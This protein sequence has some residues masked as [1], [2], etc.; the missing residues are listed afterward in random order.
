MKGIIHR[1]LKP[2]NVLVTAAGEPKV[3]DFG[4]AKAT[5]P[6][7]ASMNTVSGAAIGTPYYMAPEQAEGR[8]RDID[9]RTDVFSLGVM[10][11]ESIAG[12]VPFRGESLME[13]L[14]RIRNDDPPRFRGPTDLWLIVA[15]ALEKEKARRY[16]TADSLAEDL[17]RFLSGDPVSARAATLGF[18]ARRWIRRNPARAAGAAGA[19]LVAIAATGWWW[20][21]PGR[22]EFRSKTAGVWF[23]VDGRPAS[24]GGI[25]VRAGRHR[26][27]AGADGHVTES[28]DEFEVARGESRTVEFLLDRETVPVR[29]SC[30]TEA[31]MVEIE[32]VDYGLPLRGH[33]LP[34]GSYRVTLKARG[35]WSLARTVHAEAGKF[36]SVDWPDMPESGYWATPI[37]D[38]TAG[39]VAVEDIDGDGVADTRHLHYNQLMILDGRTGACIRRTVCTETLDRVDV[40]RLDIDGDTVTDDLVVELSGEQLEVRAFSAKAVQEVPEGESPSEVPGQRLLWAKTIP[41]RPGRAL[42]LLE[43]DV[44]WIPT[45]SGFTRISASDGRT[46]GQEDLSY[47]PAFWRVAGGGILVSGGPEGRLYSTEGQCVWKTP[48]PAPWSGVYV[49]SGQMGHYPDLPCVVM[50]DPDGVTGLDPSDGHILWHTSA[51][52]PRASW[53]LVE[54]DSDSPDR[55][56]ALDGGGRAIVH[57]IDSGRPLFEL[58]A[59]RKFTRLAP[60]C[61]LS[62]EGLA[63]ECFGL[64]DGSL[65]W[66]SVLPGPMATHAAYWRRGRTV[67]TL[68]VTTDRRLVI[69]GDDGAALREIRI[70]FLPAS[71]QPLDLDGDE[72][73]DTLLWGY[74][75]QRYLSNRVLWSRLLSNEGRS[76]PVV[77]PTRRGPVVLYQDRWADN[78]KKSLRAFDGASGAELWRYE[79]SMD[80]VR[81]PTL[82]DLDADGVPEVWTLSNEPPAGQGIRVLSAQEGKVVAVFPFRVPDDSYAPPTVVDFEGD[83]QLEVGVFGYRRGFQILRREDPSPRAP[84][85]SGMTM[86]SSAVEDVDGDGKPEIVAC[87]G[88]GGT[89]GVMRAFDGSGGAVWTLDSDEY[90]RSEPVVADLDGDGR[91]E[92]V[93][94]GSRDILVVTLGGRIQSRW[95]GLGGGRGGVLPVDVDLDGRTEILTG[96]SDGIAL[97]SADGTP[98]WTRHG[99]AV[100]GRVAVASLPRGRIALGIDA[101]GLLWALDLA[102]GRPV[103]R[104]D[105]GGRSE[106]GLTLADLTGDGVPEALAGLSNQRFVVVDLR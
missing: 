81:E 33:R 48:H 53:V 28:R 13:V 44:L 95:Q 100:A 54:R 83:G 36:P 43:G 71:I 79:P 69:L 57:E 101:K 59:P 51:P 50:S 88:T 47:S 2:G 60:G 30:E 102:T 35:R 5:A 7:A 18:L 103:W 96:T 32:G 55:L 46:L 82:H 11:Y 21:R 93:V 74:G 87:W 76:R 4:L 68:V 65:R 34:T 63:L 94:Q 49:A 1:D 72:R 77:A 89:R 97:L 19:A 91:R 92:I 37:T 29:M 9:I 26:V 78:G 98:R 58:N 80:P 73:T 42:S 52:F 23:E 105:L 61:I 24:A 41:V 40:H 86:W 99:D 75:V 10:L 3:L 25:E 8:V 20:T 56:V 70:S 15:K 31:A 6:G 104:V 106:C 17:D 39:C 67:E 66:K 14:S 64:A 84:T 12:Q 16:A 62:G 90:L 22:I 38:G 85:P 27:R 45:S